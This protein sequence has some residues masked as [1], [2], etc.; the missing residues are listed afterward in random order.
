MGWGL[1]ILLC[2]EMGMISGTFNL[3][4]FLLGIPRI[5]ISIVSIDDSLESHE[6]FLAR[7]VQRNPLHY[8]IELQTGICFDN[9]CRPLDIVIYWNI[10]G[11]YLGFELL[12]GEFLSKYDHT[13]FTKRSM[14]NC[15]IC[16]QTHSCHWVILSLKS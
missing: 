1:L 6:I 11:R 10:T 2:F 16:W 12:D 15:I 3:L 9:K 8:F 4:P 5:I 7:T 13:P 14:R